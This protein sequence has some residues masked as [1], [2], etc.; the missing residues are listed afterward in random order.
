[1]ETSTSQKS[2]VVTSKQV[3]EIP[4]NGRDFQSL[5]RTLPGVVS[6]DTSDFR[7]AFNNTN[8]FNV[9][10]QRGSSNNVFLDGAIN[11]RSGRQRR[12]VHAGQPDAVGEFRSNT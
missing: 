7:L 2:F 1:M 5:M 10:G 3:T 9:N 4:L 12:P 11:H 8:A 6:N